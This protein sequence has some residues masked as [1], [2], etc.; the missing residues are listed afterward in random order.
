MAGEVTVNSYTSSML[1]I[2]PTNEGFRFDS[3]WAPFG[4]FFESRGAKNRDMPP[5]RFLRDMTSGTVDWQVKC[6]VVQNYE[7]L[8]GQ[9]ISRYGSRVGG[10]PD[11]PGMNQ[12][13]EQV[14]YPISKMLERAPSSE[15]IGFTDRGRSLLDMATSTQQWSLAEY[16][17]DRGVQWSKQSLMSGAP[18]EA[19]IVAS[20]QLQNWINQQVNDYLPGTSAEEERIKWLSIWQDRF[21]ASGGCVD[22]SPQLNWRSRLAEIRGWQAGQ[23]ITDTPASFWISRMTSVSNTGFVAID[24]A[25]SHIPAIITHW[26][27]FFTSHGVDLYSVSIPRG[28]DMKDAVGINDFWCNI[29]NHEEW[30]GVINSAVRKYKL[31]EVAIKSQSK[32]LPTPAMK[33]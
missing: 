1:P 32:S 10:D 13:N 28:K 6:P 22:A 19:L 9:L 11:Y 18:L 2:Q 24:K 12:S 21:I 16:L 17:W 26:A 8:V 23:S 25:Q 33:I 30:L 31:Q 7:S 20:L 5:D 27:N 14:K 4:V 3:E 29:K 15:L